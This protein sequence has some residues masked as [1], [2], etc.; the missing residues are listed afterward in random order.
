[1]KIVFH[2]YKKQEK[3]KYKVMN[4][5]DEFHICMYIKMKRTYF[6]VRILLDRLHFSII[7]LIL[8]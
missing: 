8:C 7:I 6:G 3:R 2:F 4:K 1:M 5:T